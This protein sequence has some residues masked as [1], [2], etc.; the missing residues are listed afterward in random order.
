MYEVFFKDCSFSLNDDKDLNK[1]CSVLT[2]R[3][4]AGGL[5]KS[6]GK[7][8]V[9]ERNGFYDLPKGHIEIGESAENCA[10]R[11]VEDECGV[12]DLQILKSMPSTLHIYRLNQESILKR[13]Y[14][15]EMTCPDGQ[16][17]I[18]QTEEGIT[19]AFWFPITDLDAIIH[20]FYPSLQNNLENYQIYK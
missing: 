7:L 17:P 5:V 9:I 20:L 6:N 14:W 18:P 11:E 8:L 16:I 15:F 2:L 10:I 13:T 3:E 4:A 1:L 12:K 19:R